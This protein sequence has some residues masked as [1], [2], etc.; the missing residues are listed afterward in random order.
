M[1]LSSLTDTPFQLQLCFPEVFNRLEKLAADS[2]TDTGIRA[3]Q[4]L[5]EAAPF[6]E[7]RHGITDIQ[8][9]TQNAPL[10]RRLLA[11]YF[12]EALTLNEIKA[13]SI[14]FMDVVFN[15]SQRFQN[16]LAA[17]GSGS[18]FSINIRDFDYHQY[19]VL[20]CCIILNEFY[21][22]QLDFGKPLFFDIPT[23]DGITKHYRIL[24]NADFLEIYPTEKSV[25][26]TEEDIDEL[27]NSYDNLALW[28]EK[29][30]KDSWVLKGFA[31]ATLYDA[32][33]E[34]AV[35]ILK[36]K[37]L[38]INAAG[39]RDSIAS[40]F[41]SIFRIK[42]IEVGFTVY[43]KKENTLS[44]DMFGQQLPSFILEQ[45]ETEHA[46]KLLCQRASDC[47]LRKKTLFAVSDI[48]E[49]HAAFPENELGP[50]FIRQGIKSFILCPIV[51]NGQLFGILEVVSTKSKALNSINANKLDVVLPFITDTTERLAAELQNQVQAIIQTRYTTVHNSV[52]WRFQEEAQ[53]Y[54][55]ASQLGR[56]YQLQ[57][58]VFKDVHP[59]YGQIDIKGS[60]EA[61]NTSVLRD[62]QY[63]LSQLTLLLQQ[64]S[65]QLPEE[66]FTAETAEINHYLAALTMPLKAAT[67][68]YIVTWLMRQVHPRLQ[69]IAHPQL[70]ACINS[71]FENNEKETG[72]F[73][74]ERRKYETSIAMVNDQLAAH[75]DLRQTEAQEVHPHYFERFKTDGIEHN[76]YLGRSICPDKLYDQLRL[77]QIRLWQL[78]VLC[79]M[80]A[81]H[82]RIKPTLPCPLDVTSL[83]LLYHS[84]I[85]IRFRMDEKRF[86]VD[87]S[88]NARFEIVK[89]RIDKACIKNTTERIT[90]TGKI[91]IVYLN[92]P[93]EAEYRQYIQILQARNLLLPEVEQYDIEDLQGISGLKMLRV[94]VQRS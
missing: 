7:L 56:S 10:I 30:P 20:S 43:N 33:V 60:S 8:Q 59:L 46:D 2:D 69:A 24:Y 78:E 6:P 52:Q 21:G 63:Q 5:Q 71:Y 61:R 23:A 35:S 93:E 48:E 58:V 3:R 55:L 44:F 68:Q 27:R 11:D 40:I 53:R 79:E 41:Q 14:P 89:K 34:N 66:D 65:R 73:H 75:L 37:L 18:S 16:I 13:V 42:E 90:Q 45:R 84:T 57:E 29:F 19:Y 15:H 39:F 47:L 54:I 82:H 76:L 62:M 1:P 49:Y 22:T 38:G 9:I 67:E 85:D 88:Y 12:P 64:I 32:T 4:L 80:E 31:I 28:K 83:I 94:A 72:A 92:D 36:E 25:S 86:D 17:A 87:G 77:Y 26:L 81:L 91:T 74:C 51:K 50:R 70:Q